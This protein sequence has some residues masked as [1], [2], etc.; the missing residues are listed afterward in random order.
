MDSTHFDLTGQRFGELIAL[1]EIGKTKGGAT[2]WL[3]QCSCGKYTKVTVGSLRH[4]TKPTR[5]C[6]SCV[7]IK[8]WTPIFEGIICKIPLSSGKFALVDAWDY[9]KIKAYKWTQ[10]DNDYVVAWNKTAKRSTRL[11]RLVLDNPEGQDVDHENHDKLDNR[12]QN[13]RPCTRSQNCMNSIDRENKLGVRGVHE[14]KNGGYVAQIQANNKKIYL[15]IFPNIEDAA[16]V[17]YQAE[18]RYHD[19]FRYSR[20]RL[21]S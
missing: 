4:K 9:D 19:E 14:H 17:R 3:C 18:I 15:G 12:K 13:L 2:L 11:S 8:K 16:E 6:R 20:S 10:D 7:H 21:C 5:K 1:K